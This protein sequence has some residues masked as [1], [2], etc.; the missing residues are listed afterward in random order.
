MS[1]RVNEA[2]A[3]AAVAL[4]SL[5]GAVDAHAVCTQIGVIEYSSTGA[6]STTLY[7]TSVTAVLPA[8]GYAAKQVAQVTG[9]AAQCPAAGTFR[10]G[11]TVNLRLSASINNRGPGSGLDRAFACDT[12]R[13]PPSPEILNAGAPML[14]QAAAPAGD[15]IEDRT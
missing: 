15:L 13:D 4:V 12:E 3:G 9:N 7:I 10:P 5:F 14:G 6:A 11:G 2:V 1:G 8:F